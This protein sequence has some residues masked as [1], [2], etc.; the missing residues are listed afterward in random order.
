MT[1]RIVKLVSR[2]EEGADGMRW[3]LETVDILDEHVDCAVRKWESDVVDSET[4]DLD[5]KLLD[6][7]NREKTD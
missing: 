3:L 6:F 1:D 2:G 7:M 5:E 4:T